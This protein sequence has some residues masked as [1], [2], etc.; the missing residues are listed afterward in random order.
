MGSLILI[1]LKKENDFRLVADYR[2]L[3]KKIAGN[4][5]P[6]P[7]LQTTL[8]SLDNQKNFS[9]LDLKE[10]FYSVE[11]SPSSIPK[12]AIITPCGLYEYLRINFGLEDSVNVYC[13][14]ISSVLGHL[15]HNEVIN[16]VDD[17]IVLGE[18]FEKHLNNIDKTMEAFSRNGLILKIENANSS[19]KRQ[20]FWTKDHT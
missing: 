10:A 1:V 14:M 17:S 6:I 19:N 12:T 4:A 16:N 9:T 8:T 11:H 13:R 2:K 5:W 7:H 3:T 20:F 15:R 18:S